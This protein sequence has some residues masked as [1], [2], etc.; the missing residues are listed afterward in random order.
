M[1]HS[2]KPHGICWWLGGSDLCT[3]LGVATEPQESALELCLFHSLRVSINACVASGRVPSELS[4]WRPARTR[5]LVGSV[6]LEA[7]DS[8]G[9]CW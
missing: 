3:G 8:D 4:C 5:G 9:C 6:T 2:K 7:G 1:A